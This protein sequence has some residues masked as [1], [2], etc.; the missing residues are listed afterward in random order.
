MSL[1]STIADQKANRRWVVVTAPTEEP[2]TKAELKTFARIDGSDEDTLLE[3]FIKAARLQVEN[4]LNKSLIQKTIDLFFDYWPE[5]PITL[6]RGPIISITGIY[7]L[8][9]DDTETTYS[10]SSYY[11]GT[12]SDQLIIKRST[13]PPI[14]NNRSFGGFKIK[15]KAGYGN[16][17]SDVPEIIRQ[18]ISL[19]AT[20]IY[21]NRVIGEE[22]TP[23][24]LLLLKS[25]KLYNI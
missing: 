11:L 20:N 22:P 6:P 16:N 25:Y 4:Y 9:E 7:T 21:E 24:S 3:E 2:I 23:E 18:A 17:A 12:N 13:T 10:S 8:D 14:N 5:N 1:I 15:Y 19:C